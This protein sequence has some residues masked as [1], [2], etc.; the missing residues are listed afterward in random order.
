MVL[1][2]NYTVVNFNDLFIQLAPESRMNGLLKN[3]LS[4]PNF[5]CV[6][7]NTH[8]LKLLKAGDAMFMHSNTFCFC[9]SVMNS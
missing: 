2:L 5:K 6:G 8:L 7:E 3:Q 1:P 9:L 4:Q